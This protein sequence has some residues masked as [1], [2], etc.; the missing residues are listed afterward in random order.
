MHSFVTLH[1]AE[2]GALE[3]PACARKNL[4]PKV[5]IGSAYV[6]K[7]REVRDL[8]TGTYH[9]YSPHQDADACAMQAAFLPPAR[10]VMAQPK[11][12]LATAA[13]WGAGLVI[14]F[15]LSALAGIF[16]QA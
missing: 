14:I 15:G 12:R 4:V 9:G 3:S 7:R 5:A 8:G 13:W 1:A 6:P 16:S 11:N 2:I 10:G